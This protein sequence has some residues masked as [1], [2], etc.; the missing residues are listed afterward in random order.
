M[1]L[2][3]YIETTPVTDS[4]V[5][6]Y[7]AFLLDDVD[8]IINKISGGVSLT[9]TARL[10]KLAILKV[11]KEIADN[12]EDYSK[13]KFEIYTNSKPCVDLVNIWIDSWRLNM[14]RRASGQPADDLDILIPLSSYL[15]DFGER[16]SVMK[17]NGFLGLKWHEKVIAVAQTAKE[18]YEK[19]LKKET[20]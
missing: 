11:L 13:P 14:W 9:S 4:G 15:D 19:A 20:K 3:W 8:N 10:E 6:G 5:G 16:I 2:R 1:T 12:E 17:I 18:N 7:A